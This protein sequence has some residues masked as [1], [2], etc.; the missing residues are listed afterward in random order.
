MQPMFVH[1]LHNLSVVTQSGVRIGSLKD[2]VIDVDSGRVIQ[3]AV[4]QGLLGGA[5]LLVA[6]DEVVE[7]RPDAV[8]VTDALV[9]G[10]S[11]VVAA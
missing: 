6:S 3:Y 10:S 4:K 7:I 2:V 5:D 11:A 8:V 1:D 9:R